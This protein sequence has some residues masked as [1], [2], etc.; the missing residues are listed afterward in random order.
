M[1]L[2]IKSADVGDIELGKVKNAGNIIAL[3]GNPNTGKS[4]VFNNLTGLKQ[5]TGNWS[6]KTVTNAAGDFSHKDENFI[7]VDLP[8]IYSVN[9]VSLE[10]KWAVEYIMGG[11]AKTVVIVLDATCLE[12]NLILALQVINIC[13]NCIVCVNL[14]DEAK[15][16]NIQID[17]VKLE[18]MLGVPVVGTSAR[19]G[20]G[21]EELKNV[22]YRKVCKEDSV[23]VMAASV[24]NIEL[25]PLLIRVNEIY[26]SAVVAPDNISDT[27]DRKIDNI[28][29]SKKYGIPIMLGILGCVF[30]ITI[31]GANYPS[32]LLS[33]LFNYIEDWLYG[34]MVN[35]KVPDVIIGIFVE[36][37]FR[38]LGWVVAVML[39]PMAIFFPL[40]T[41]LEDLG[42]LPRMAFNLD[43]FFK[44]AKAHGKMVL[45]M[46]MGFG[47][48]AAGVVSTRII[49]SPRE[50]LLAIITNNF[51]PCNGR[52]PSLI[53]L[54][55][56]FIAGLGSGF[57]SLKVTGIILLAIVSSV[58]ITLIVSRILSETLLKGEASSFILELPPYR[59]PQLGKTIVRSLTDRTL[60]VLGRAIV[61][62]APAGAIIWLMQ[63]FY[64]DGQSLLT[65]V[66][67][68]MDPAGKALGL[69][70]Y[71]LTA[72]I[73]GLPANEIVIPL[74][75][76]FYTG[77][78]GLMEYE[79]LSDLGHL[80][81]NNGWTY[82]T[83][84]CTM[85]FSL[86]HFPCSTTLMTIRKETKSWKWTGVAFLLPTLVGVIIC[87][88]VNLLL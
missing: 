17:L 15:K 65:Y 61:V 71:I 70:G 2:S 31:V 50:R 30:W 27:I 23:Q 64:I 7:V 81:I 77:N 46:C 47:C 52:F 56:I 82:K 66:G 39:P 26:K 11:E 72:F 32:G 57:A 10:E 33:S 12:R 29:M 13:N 76:M 78:S 19:S 20:T 75:I 34:V 69:D 53:M 63:N 24:A 68:F 21:M 36:G 28:V 6:G 83:A 22:V 16:K 79:S 41:L 55:T 42:Y 14:M 86:N 67:E 3:V 35:I 85:L 8:G 51:V 60:F 4:T 58:V 5:H 25:E 54:A 1:G 73:L 88:G 37:M 84:I 62:A 80:L 48:N 43:R 18:E 44:K 38:T 40:F 45:T 9:P 49:D 59:K 87:F 74:I